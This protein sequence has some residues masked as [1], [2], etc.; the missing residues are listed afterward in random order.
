MSQFVPGRPFQPNLMFCDNE[1]D[2]Q[3]NG[4][5]SELSDII[6]MVCA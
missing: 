1:I 4:K 3:S 5:M 6:R 2:S